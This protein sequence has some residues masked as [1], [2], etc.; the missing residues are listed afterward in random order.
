MLNTK[1]IAVCLSAGLLGAAGCETYEL[2]P[3]V[4]QLYETD[5]ETCADVGQEAPCPLLDVDNAGLSSSVDPQLLL[6]RFGFESSRGDIERLFVRYEAPGQSPAQ[7]Q[8]PFSPEASEGSASDPLRCL[9][10]TLD[11][12][13]ALPGSATEGILA[14]EVD[15]L[16]TET[17]P[18]AI[19]VWLS[20]ALEL[21][22][23]V[24]RWQFTVTE[25]VRDE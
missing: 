11:G 18:H 1:T 14:V 25:P 21:E 8:C 19:S 22:S 5:A 15:V 7:R 17:G 20:D 9:R 23:P 3:D 24:L 4:V 6:L 10:A 2:G 13:D 12:S 16:A